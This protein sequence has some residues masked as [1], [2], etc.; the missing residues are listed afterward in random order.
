[1]NVMIF[2]KPAW[3]LAKDAAYRHI[4]TTEAKTMDQTV[5]DEIEELRS[6]AN[7]LSAIIKDARQTLATNQ[8]SLEQETLQIQGVT[9]LMNG[10][11]EDFRNAT[12][13]AI[14]AIARRIE[15]KT[16]ALSRDL[17]EFQNR[18]TAV[19]TRAEQWR[20]RA[21]TDALTRLPNRRA[22][23]DFISQTMRATGGS[24]GGVTGI[25]IADI[26]RF[27]GINDAHGHVVGDA[28]LRF[29]AL[30]LR[31]NLRNEDFVARWGG[32]E[33]V[34][35]LPNT[36]LMTAQSVCER[37]RKELEDRNFNLRDSG[38][39]IGKVTI[40]IGLTMLR[41]NDTMEQALDRADRALYAAKSSGRN[42]IRASQ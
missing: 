36:D 22:A 29:V 39:P 3:L 25:A 20:T 9:A 28:V 30:T 40:S 4:R 2:Q 35:V 5:R 31:R 13:E 15:D 1:M 12:I 19:E 26:D 34:L 33:F 21:L 32:E 14:A 17:H 23:E 41:P 38:K 24:S 27:K 7:V 42:T 11:P 16:T 37:L 10:I 8:A 18:V 6:L